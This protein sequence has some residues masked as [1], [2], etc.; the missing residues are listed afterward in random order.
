[1]TTRINFNIDEALKNA[2]MK[3]ASQK[4]VSLST[5]LN[6]ATRAFVADTLD[7]GIVDRLLADD[8]ARSNDDIKHGRVTPHTDVLKELGILH[9]HCQTATERTRKIPP[10]THPGQGC[11]LCIPAQPA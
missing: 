6:Q 11:P 8:I 5:V 7:I 4:G 10:K 1:M 3:K 2:A 9:V